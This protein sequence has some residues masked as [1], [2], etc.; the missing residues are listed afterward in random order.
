MRILKDTKA[1][2]TLFLIILL[3]VSAIIGALLSYLWVVGYYESLEYRNPEAPSITMTNAAFNPQNTTHFNLT[4]LYPTYSASRDPA[5]I[6]KITISTRDSVAHDVASVQPA[7]PYELPRGESE[8]FECSWNWANYTGDIVEFSVALEEGSG[9]AREFRTP[10]VDLRITD[11]SF[12]STISVSHFNMTLENSEASTTYVNITRIAVDGEEVTAFDSYTLPLSLHPDDSIPLK[13]SWDWTEYQGKSVTISVETLQGY[14]GYYPE[15]P[16]PISLPSPIILEITEARFD[17]T[18]TTRFNL[19]VR[20]SEES[21]T[22]VSVSEIAVTVENET[23]SDITVLPPLALPHRLHPNNETTFECS[24]NWTNHREKNVTIT[25]NTLQDVANSTTQVTTPRVILS[26]AD[27]LLNV[28]DT[29]HFNVTVRNSE[30][31]LE[32]FVNITSIYVENGARESLT[33]V[34]PP[35][36]GYA[37]YVNESVT[38]KCEW[39]WTSYWNEEVTITAESLQGYSASLTE[40]V[41]APV[42]VSAAFFNDTAT[43]HFNLTV[44]NHNLAPLYVIV[45]NITVTLENGTIHEVSVAA[46]ANL[47][48]ILHPG[49]SITFK[50]LWNWTGY[51]DGDVTLT[52]FT[53]EGYEASYR[54]RTP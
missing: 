45:T 16:E 3:I 38:F 46:P 9:A 19:T 29:S 17:I 27:V 35:S 40:V 18:E 47:P 42:Y 48:F 7:L 32:E 11:V 44:K 30:F 6:T 43:D 34:P 8:E 5:K 49:E 1:I 37:L 51:H 50:C 22:Y 20:N 13:A 54:T 33:V 41:P 31:S 12:N 23:F 4:L 53:L 24:W 26:V 14:V 21:P 36:L 28:T 2:S 15:P 52:I 39:D 25:V 10:L